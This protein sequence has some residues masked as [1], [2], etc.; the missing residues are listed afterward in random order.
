M[1]LDELVK[2]YKDYVNQENQLKKTF[3]VWNQID[4]DHATVNDFVNQVLEIPKENVSTIKKNNRESLFHSINTEMAVMGRNA[5]GL[6]NG[7]THYTS[8][9][10]KTSNKMFGNAMGHSY[11][12]NE[13]GYKFM[14][15]L[16]Q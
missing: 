11:R 3:E 4:V 10:V 8:H 6:F 16:V 12:L 15:Q 13:R 5:Y 7:L 1:K 14:N 2:F 9:V